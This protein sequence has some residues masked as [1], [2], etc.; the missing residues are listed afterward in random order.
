MSVSPTSSRVSATS[1]TLRPVRPSDRDR[2][3]WWRNDPETRRASFDAAE[4]PL[5]LH[6]RW[7]D[8]SLERDNRKM[9]IVVVQGHPEGVV[10]LDTAGSAATVSINLAPEWRGRGVGAIALRKLAAISFKE[11]KLRRLVASVKE[12]NLASLAAF[13]KANFA[14]T[15]RRDG[16]VT[17]QRARSR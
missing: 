1:V 8:A 5:D 3:L 17:L 11:L 7:F 13:K 12:E 15:R 9:Y 2:I 14:E 16:I 6:E 10:R 4:I